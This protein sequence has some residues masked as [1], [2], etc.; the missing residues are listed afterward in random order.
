M[1]TEF[2]YRAGDSDIASVFAGVQVGDYPDEKELLLKNL[3]ARDYNPVDMSNNELA[4][5]HVRFM[6]GGAGRRAIKRNSFPYRISRKTRRTDSFFESIR[7]K[8]EYHVIPL[9]KSWSSLWASIDR[10]TI[11]RSREAKIY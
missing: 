2:N 9:S 11:E 5:M 3:A 6:V 1:I 10:N 7:D 8:M 4:K